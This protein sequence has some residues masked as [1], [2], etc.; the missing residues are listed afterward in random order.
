[1]GKN[2]KLTW[3]VLFI[4]FSMSGMTF[5]SLFGYFLF[6]FLLWMVGGELNFNMVEIIT[7]TK[8]GVFGGCVA[9]FGVVLM[10]LLKVKGF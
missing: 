6:A 5:L 4:A 2:N 9:G 1:M 10:K 7:Y 8:I 3:A